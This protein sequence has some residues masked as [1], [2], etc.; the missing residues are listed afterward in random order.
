[1]GCISTALV[2]IVRGAGLRLSSSATSAEDAFDAVTAFTSDGFTLGNTVLNESATSSVA[3]TWDAGSSTVTNTQGSI[4][5]QVRAN[6]SAGFSVVTYTGNGTAGATWGHGLNAT[7]GMIVIKA[8][9]SVADGS[10]FV[11]HSGMGLGYA[12]LLLNS[13]VEN[14]GT[15]GNVV[16]FDIWNNTAATSSVVTVGSYN[17]VNE[18]TKNYVAYCFAPVA[19]YSSFG[20]YTGNGSSTDGPFVYTGFKPR[21]ILIKGSSVANTD[22]AIID[23]ARDTYNIATDYLAANSSGAEQTLNLLD[24]VSNGFKIKAYTDSTNQNGQ[25]FVWAAFAEHPFA[26]SRAR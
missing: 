26:T 11:G 15:P 14:N 6:A 8:R 1:M 3:W 17:G 10:W 22:W 19:G 2:D 4:T 7:P 24:V 25:T 18:S 23:T 12:R 5:S 21:F 9:D 16:A 20:S 13:T